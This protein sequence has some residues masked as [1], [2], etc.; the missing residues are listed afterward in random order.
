MSLLLSL[1]LAFAQEE[2]DVVGL[3]KTIETTTGD[4]AAVAYAALAQCDVE[5]AQRFAKTTVITFLPSEAGY[6][7]AMW[8]MRLE[9]E[10]F[11]V[12]WMTKELGP[13]EKK[14]L[15]RTLGE[16]CQEDEQIQKFFINRAENFTAD[17]WKHR[18]YQYL[19]TC[20]VAPIREILTTQLDAGVEQGRSQYFSLMGVYAR[21]MMLDSLPKLGEILGATDDEEIQ[22]NV[23]SS[24][25]EAGDEIKKNDPGNKGA[26]R[27]MNVESTKIVMANA[28]KMTQKALGQ[29]RI[30]LNGIEAEAEADA[31]AGFYYREKIQEDESF[32]WGVIAIENTLCKNN[33]EKQGIHAGPIIEQG[34]TWADQLE[35]RVKEV[36]DFSWD[37]T[38]G[39]DCKGKSEFLYFVPEEPFSNLDE[40]TVWA[41][42]IKTEQLNTDIKKPLILDHDPIEL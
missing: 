38:L 33:K 18:Y 42:K 8:A 22:I 17:F 9:Q 41:E 36:V 32:L 11:V 21:N 25:L 16:V 40:Y 27:K 30:S 2:C 10:Q 37:M 24:I 4:E 39:E 7:A 26:L 14:Q 3:S 6:E 15:L 35:D 23:L 5:K 19:T 29:A 31:L 20:R 13:S 1:S 12:E 28:E 34:T